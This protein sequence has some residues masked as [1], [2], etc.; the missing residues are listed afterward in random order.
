[1][2][3]NVIIHMM[4]KYTFA[5]HLMLLAYKFLRQPFTSVMSDYRAYNWLTC[6]C[7]L[8]PLYPVFKAQGR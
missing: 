2:G 6:L 3:V 5:S 7:K 8:K 1:M 4:K